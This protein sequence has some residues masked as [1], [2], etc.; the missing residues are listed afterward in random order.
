MKTIIEIEELKN[1]MQKGENL[2]LID[3]RFSLGSPEKGR[4][5]YQKGHIPGSIYLDLEK[6]L[7]SPV[8]EHGG[9]HPLPKMEEFKSTLEKAGIE[10]EMKVVISDGGDGAFAGRCWWLLK[11]AGHKDAFILNGGY[12]LWREED[13]PVEQT[14]PSYEASKYELQI[15]NDMLAG[16]EEV[17]EASEGR[18]KAILI[19]SRAYSRY[20][21]KEEP[22]DKIAG[23]IPGAVNKD[24]SKGFRN[25][26]W[27]P[28][29]D[30]KKR[31][32]EFPEDA[33]IIVYCG[34]GVTAT[35]NVLSLLEAGYKNVK[36][37]AGS[38]SDWV[39]YPENP[40]ENIS[41]Q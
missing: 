36:L 34:S 19:D 18:N 16:Y 23:H 4:E 11:Y 15:K 2:R 17:K 39:S 12:K 7:S 28:V 22:I 20:I 41:T 30:Q 37:Y 24:W 32:S 33:R 25:G 10:P 6:D 13:L 14:I 9:R 27:L 21:G 29:E 5:E 38:Y 3:C 31:F 26:K 8:S 40:V 1:L 35:P